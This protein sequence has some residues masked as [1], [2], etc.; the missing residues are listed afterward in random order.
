MYG[1]KYLGENLEYI[2]ENLNKNALNH[3]SKI[4]IKKQKVYRKINE[5]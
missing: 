5:R 1:H 4:Q 2:M 3:I